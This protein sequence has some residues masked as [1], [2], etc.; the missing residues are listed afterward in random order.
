M[1]LLYMLH[2]LTSTLQETTLSLRTSAVHVI[3]IWRI[4]MAEKIH[5]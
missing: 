4:N 5:F 3:P 2:N 1:L